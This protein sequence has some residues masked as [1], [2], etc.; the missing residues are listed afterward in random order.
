MKPLRSRG[1]K[2]PWR[3]AQSAAVGADQHDPPHRGAGCDLE[4][5]CA[6]LAGMAA[7]IVTQDGAFFA[8]RLGDSR[9]SYRN[10]FERDGR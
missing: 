1:A 7:Y 9:A 4:G 8:V 2:Q 5:S 6:I 3:A 10:V